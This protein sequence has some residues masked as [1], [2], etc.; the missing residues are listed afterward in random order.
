[1]RAACRGSQA[2][3]SV[4]GATQAVS[5]MS[6]CATRVAAAIDPYIEPPE[7]E[8]VRCSLEPDKNWRWCQGDG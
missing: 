4:T 6:R 5:W 7:P 3:L 1:M 8:E 2:A